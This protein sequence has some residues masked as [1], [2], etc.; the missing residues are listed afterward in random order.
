MIKNLLNYKKI[1]KCTTQKGDIFVL[2]EFDPNTKQILLRK[3]KSPTAS[4]IL[5]AFHRVVSILVERRK[6]LSANLPPPIQQTI[7]G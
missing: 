6:R 1:R 7:N 3:Y 4:N 2:E 5:L